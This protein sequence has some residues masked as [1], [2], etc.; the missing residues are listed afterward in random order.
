MIKK[1]DVFVQEFMEVFDAN[2]TTGEKAAVITAVIFICQRL[3]EEIKEIADMRRAESVIALEAI[4]K[5]QDRKWKAVVRR[6]DP[7]KLPLVPEPEAFQIV[8]GQYK[9]MA[10]RK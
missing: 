10:K 8:W 3:I 6:L 1:A 9:H 4:V 7:D 5:E 2:K